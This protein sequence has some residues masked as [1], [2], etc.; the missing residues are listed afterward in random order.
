MH[1]TICFLVCP[2]ASQGNINKFADSGI[3]WPHFSPV[4]SSALVQRSQDTL[5]SKGWLLLEAWS[6]LPAFTGF[7][8]HNSYIRPLWLPSERTL[9]INSTW[10]FSEMLLKGERKAAE[11]QQSHSESCLICAVFLAGRN[12]LPPVQFVAVLKQHKICLFFYIQLQTNS[13]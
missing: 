13:D 3:S 11:A 9:L 10:F 12:T 5:V 1:D 8:L 4:P 6:L 7:N 2:P